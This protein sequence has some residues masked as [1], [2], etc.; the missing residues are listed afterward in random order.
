M[1]E[2]PAPYGCAGLAIILGGVA[3]ILS[4]LLSGPRGDVTGSLYTGCASIVLVFAGLAALMHHFREMREARYGEELQE[5][6]DLD[7]LVLH[8][9]SIALPARVARGLAT[10]EVTAGSA[11]ALFDHVE[12]R[13][14]AALSFV[15]VRDV[16]D[17]DCDVE[18]A[19]DRTARALEDRIRVD[20]LASYRDEA[21]ASVASAGEAG[22]AVVSVL[23]VA[24]PT[25]RGTLA[26]RRIED[27]RALR[28]AIL[29]TA[30]AH[31][32][33]ARIVLTP[34]AAD[35]SFDEDALRAAFPEL[36]RLPIE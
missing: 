23:V 34:A 14:P 10:C 6:S 24:H 30:P 1:N 9:V 29:P 11:H 3:A 27:A 25:P 21:R 22:L 8:R 35:A 32:R 15:H 4:C 2:R 7:V 18:A 36:L 16:L 33:A 19:L 12:A 20:T 31:T 5:A 28:D 13:L 26:V 17:V